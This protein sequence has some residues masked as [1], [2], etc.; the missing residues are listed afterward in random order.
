[1]KAVAVTIRGRVQ[2]V[3]YRAWLQRTA[4]E[5]GVS[6]WVRNRG[7]EEVEA[8]L[9]GDDAAVDRVA[10]ACRE[11]PPSAVVARVETAP[12]PIGNMSGFTIRPSV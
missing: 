11:G 1:M 10:A 5:A 12:A 8:V 9:A 3:G 6:G 7:E 4:R 2:G